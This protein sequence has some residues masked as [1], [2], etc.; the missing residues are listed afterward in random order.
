MEELSKFFLQVL[1]RG[2][3]KLAFDGGTLFSSST[4]LISS[5]F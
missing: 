5:C 1:S 3:L 4:T 2:D